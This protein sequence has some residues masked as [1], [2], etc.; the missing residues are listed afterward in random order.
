M[1]GIVLNNNGATSH[2]AGNHKQTQKKALKQKYLGMP[3]VPGVVS[4]VRNRGK[5]HLMTD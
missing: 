3:E 5:R 4:G 2:L 1:P